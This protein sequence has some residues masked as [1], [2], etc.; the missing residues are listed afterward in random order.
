[1]ELKVDGISARS[2]GSQ[3]QQRSIVLAMKL[4]EAQ[5]LQQMTGEAPVIFLDDVM[6]ELDTERQDYLLNHVK[7]RQVFLTCCDPNSIQDFRQGALFHVES[8]RVSAS[9][10]TVEGMP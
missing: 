3:G 10:R 4:A 2:F 1:M 8:G 7:G 6:S 9:Q 5:V